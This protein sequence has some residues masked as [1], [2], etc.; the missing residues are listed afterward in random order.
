MHD[1][2]IP[3]IVVPMRTNVHAA[4]LVSRILLDDV[5][6]ISP[7]LTLEGTY[8]VSTIE[9]VLGTGAT[10][11]YKVRLLVSKFSYDYACT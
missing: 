1:F 5:E 11:V 3:L 10:L 6:H 2:S 9:I 8:L 4:D 7:P